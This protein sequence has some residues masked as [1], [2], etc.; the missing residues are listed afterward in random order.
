MEIKEKLN[1]GF[2]KPSHS[3]GKVMNFQWKYESL[4]L[5]FAEKRAILLRDH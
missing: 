1:N 4:V 2:S 5:P 3:L